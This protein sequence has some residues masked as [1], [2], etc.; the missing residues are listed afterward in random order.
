MCARAAIAATAAAVALF[1]AGQEAEAQYNPVASCSLSPAEFQS[2]FQ[3]G[4][5]ATNGQVKFADSVAF[6]K[7]NSICDF[8]KWAHQMFL[9]ITSPKGNQI[10][11]NSPAFYNVLIDAEGNGHYVS[12]AQNG[13]LLGLRSGVNKFSLRS[14][15]SDEI[16]P[17]GQAGGG[18]SL[19]SL[20]GSVVYFGVHANDVFAWFNTAVTNGDLPD[21]TP[22]PASAEDLA[23]IVDYALEHGAILPDSQAMTMELKT[24]WIEAD[25]VSGDISDYIVMDAEVPNYQGNVGDA[26]WTIGT[27]STVVKTLALVGMHVVGSVQGH[28]ELVWASF[29]HRSNAPDNDF[30]ISV[31][32]SPF[33]PPIAVK[34]PYNSAGNWNFMQTSGGREGA[35]V[36]QMTVAANGDLVA[37]PGNS[38]RPNDV[39]RV[40]P[41]GGEP[42]ESSAG[43]NTQLVT[44]NANVDFMLTNAP[45]G[46]DVRA[47]Y[48]Q[49]GAVWTKDGSLPSSPGDTGQQIGSLLLANSTMET[50]HQQV[51]PGIKPAFQHGCFGC[52]NTD[53][54]SG[55][56]VTPTF[57]SHLFSKSNAP[58]VPAGGKQK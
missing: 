40:N 49:L 56:A 15:K 13:A 14:S 28:S 17:G 39:Y 47:N 32:P 1:L 53:A 58:L 41:W 57:V 18:D 38:I 10:I 34:V 7:D 11:L 3:D 25:K 50:Y 22:F 35:L 24:S 29:E 43:N 8:Y 48:F 46:K 5:I 20:N 12:N 26:T 51:G 36:S 19:L 6:P 2:W 21:S 44:L 33:V 37:T 54:Q 27:P 23:P 45:G 52:H 55:G 16:Q 31:K 9:W 42:D 4:V 30:Y